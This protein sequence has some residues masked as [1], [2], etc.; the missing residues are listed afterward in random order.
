M[1]QYNNKIMERGVAIYLAFMVM[2]ILLAISLGL[3]VILIGQMKVIKGIGDSVIALYAAETGIEMVLYTDKQCYQGGC[4]SPPFSPPCKPGCSSG[5]DIFTFSPGTLDNEAVYN[6]S[7]SQEIKASGED[8]CPA[9]VD[10]CII[11]HT[12]SVGDYAKVK[13]VKR[14]IAVSR[15]ETIT[16]NICYG[17]DGIGACE[18]K[19]TDWGANEYGCIGATQRCNN[20]VCETQP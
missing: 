16:C 19:S 5:L 14:A 9:T 10:F 11:H 2:T 4:S 8:I 1:K 12:Q 3:S 18:A 17:Y 20:G 7:Y 13:K 15:L 6:A